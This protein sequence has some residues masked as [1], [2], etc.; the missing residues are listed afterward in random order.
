MERLWAPWRSSYIGRGADSGCV[1]CD[2]AKPGEDEEKL[3]LWRW[4][5]VFV[6]MNLYPY[7][8]GHLLI[9]PNRHVGDITQ[10]EGDELLEIGTASQKAVELLKKAFNPEGFNLGVN[11]GK[12]AGAGI[13][14]HFH[15]HVVPRWGGDANFMPI[16]GE[17]KVISEG[18]DQTYKKLL[19]LT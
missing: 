8:N 18:L 19:L 15:V 4:D 2:L 16:I 17:T 9:I 3:V 14:G 13:P 7:N 11:M 5:K 1:F 10:L 6:T 12:V